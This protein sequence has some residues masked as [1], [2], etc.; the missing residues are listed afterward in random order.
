MSYCVNCGVKLKNSENKC[1]LCNTKVINPNKIKTDYEPVYSNKV[2]NFKTLNYKYLSKIIIL[3]LMITSF[4]ILLLDL[5]SSKTITWSLYVV[6]SILYLG[7]HLSFA[8]IKNIYISLI[9]HLIS[10]ELFIFL[11]AYLNNG[12]HWY[13]YLVLPFIVIIWIYIMLVT[14]LFKRKKGDFLKKL[15]LGLLFCALTI[16]AVEACIDLFRFNFINYNWSF[17]AA[18]PITIIS[19]LTFIISYNKKIVDEIRQRMFIKN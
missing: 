3:L 7:T 18:I 1:P 10:T 19:T 11:I 17:Y 2:E 13:L 4:L 16:I 9:I 6:A 8:I 15:S 12:L 5:V 14:Y